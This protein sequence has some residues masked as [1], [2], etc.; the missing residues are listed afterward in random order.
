MNGKK[1]DLALEHFNS[2]K[3]VY[4]DDLKDLIRVPSI[5]FPGFDPAP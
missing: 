4:L 5:S 2:H 1:L 3:S